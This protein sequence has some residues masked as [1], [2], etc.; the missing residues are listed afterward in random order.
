[1][2]RRCRLHER[3]RA[4][5]RRRLVEVIVRTVPCRLEI[6]VR[7]VA[8]RD[9]RVV[10]PARGERLIRRDHHVGRRLEQHADVL[11]RRPRSERRA[12][13]VRRQDLRIRLA[14]IGETLRAPLTHPAPMTPP[15]TGQ[16]DARALGEGW[17]L[18]ARLHDREKPGQR[19][20]GDDGKEATNDG[21]VPPEGLLTTVERTVMREP[22]RKRKR[23]LALRATVLSMVDDTQ[24]KLTTKR[25]TRL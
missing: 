2:D 14:L 6:P 22:R 21:T 15:V 7:T 24:Q 11:G 20:D 25:I 13:V 12:R 18:R 9:D 10:A 5:P 17:L 19:E 4:V 23:S 8:R 16:E 1:D 3:P